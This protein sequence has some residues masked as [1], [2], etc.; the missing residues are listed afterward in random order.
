MLGR[1]VASVLPKSI[2][3]EVH[4]PDDKD[5]SVIIEPFIKKMIQSR[6]TSGSLLA[7]ILFLHHIEDYTAN[8]HPG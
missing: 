3:G 7:T 8:F 1:F 2:T 5:K 6:I 4:L